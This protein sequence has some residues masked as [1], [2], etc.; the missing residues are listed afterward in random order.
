MD[1]SEEDERKRKFN[2]GPSLSCSL[3]LTLKKTKMVMKMKVLS[4]GHGLRRL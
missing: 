2:E 1:C 4:F 3:L